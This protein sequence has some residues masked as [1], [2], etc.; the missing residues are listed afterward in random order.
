MQKTKSHLKIKDWEWDNKLIFWDNLWIL[1]T[2]CNDE[3]LQKQIQDNWG[4]K[5]IYIDPPFA[6]KSDFKSWAW[7]KAYWD[8]VA[9]SEFIEFIRK[10]LVLL[11]SLLAD[12]GSI[13]VHL[14]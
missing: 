10:R 6:T 2:L 8:K 11:R 7:E 5:L 3:I 12:N 14:D 13:Y 9:W 1:K 4:V